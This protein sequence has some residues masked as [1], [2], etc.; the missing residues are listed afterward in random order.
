MLLKCRYI[1]TLQHFVETYVVKMSVPSH[2]API[3][4]I[5]LINLLNLIKLYFSSPFPTRMISPSCSP[6][7]SSSSNSDLFQHTP[8]WLD[9][10]P[11]AKAR[12]KGMPHAWPSALFAVGT[13]QGT[14]HQPRAAEVF[15]LQHQPRTCISQAISPLRGGMHS[16]TFNLLVC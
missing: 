16:F 7:N 6:Q 13:G 9:K 12:D 15:V 2:E 5:N 10:S 14:Q 11:K 8:P 4:G 3:L 1:S